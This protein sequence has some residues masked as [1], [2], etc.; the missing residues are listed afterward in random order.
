MTDIEKNDLPPARQEDKIITDAPSG[1]ETNPAQNTVGNNPPVPEKKEAEV[2]PP[3]SQQEKEH[4]TYLRVLGEFNIAKNRRTRYRQYG[5]AFII[6]TGI[7]F[8]TLIFSLEAKI[9]FLTLWILTILACVAVMIIADYTY[10]K[11][12]EF[13]GFADEFDLET[14]DEEEE[15][16]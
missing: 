11:Y 12:K 8:L 16:E 2:I 14:D 6:I 1:I 7:I 9:L 3:L 4:L 5:A 15:E 13:L 10:D